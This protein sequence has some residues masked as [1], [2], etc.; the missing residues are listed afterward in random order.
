MGAFEGRGKRGEPDV[1]TRQERGPY[2][3]SVFN[4]KER[5]KDYILEQVVHRPLTPALKGEDSTFLALITGQEFPA[6]PEGYWDQNGLEQWRDHLLQVAA[7][8]TRVEVVSVPTASGIIKGTG[9]KFEAVVVNEEAEIP[10]YRAGRVANLIA[11]LL[12]WGNASVEALAKKQEIY[13]EL[14]DELASLESLRQM[15][16]D[17]RDLFANVQALSELRETVQSLLG[18]MRFGSASRLG[19]GVLPGTSVSKHNIEIVNAVY[20]E[21]RDILTPSAFRAFLRIVFGAK[22]VYPVPI[23]TVNAQGEV[24]LAEPYQTFDVHELA[25]TLPQRFQKFSKRASE[26]NPNQKK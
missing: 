1:E 22:D 25:R 17:E 26:Y 6:V 23:T 14:L 18:Q 16:L 9:E 24:V 8:R 12:I 4:N 2:G 11:S 7:T 3:P 5:H 20:Q 19:R 21:A 15:V 10:G 13:T